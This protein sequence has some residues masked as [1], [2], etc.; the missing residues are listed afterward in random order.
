M[1]SLFA[2]LGFPYNVISVVW[3]DNLAAKS[4]AENPVFHSHTKH[5][6]I[7]VHF[8]RERVENGE[9]EV[10]YIPTAYQITD[11]FTKSLAKDR[12]RFLCT[13]LRLKVCLLCKEIPMILHVPSGCKS[14]SVPLQRSLL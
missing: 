8:V 14:Q 7:D 1:R 3:S 13:K 2:E 4:M 6:E 5:I 11:I 12:F 10:R 9:I